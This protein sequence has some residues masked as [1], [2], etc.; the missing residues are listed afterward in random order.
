LASLLVLGVVA[1]GPPRDARRL[2][3][4]AGTAPSGAAPVAPVATAPAAA[5][6]TDDRAL[7]ALETQDPAQLGVVQLLLL[8]DRRLQRKRTDAQTLA[9]KLREQPELTKDGAIQRELLRLAADPETAPEALAAMAQAP[10]PIGPDLLY[11]IWTGRS[12]PSTTAE[13]ARALLYS[14]DV[15]PGASAG[16]AAA[17]E[18]RSAS[19]CADSQRALLKAQADG[20]SRAIPPLVTLSSR[21]GCG[22]AKRQDCYPCLRANPKQLV[23][24][25]KAALARRAPSY[26]RL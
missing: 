21:R 7:A 25:I 13:L 15:R 1:S 20:D 5:E 3:R 26:G 6:S 12:T 23:A 19:T 9:Q 22:A 17:L 18:L 4:S 10:A 8:H 11:E 16:L 2:P 24:S 14:R